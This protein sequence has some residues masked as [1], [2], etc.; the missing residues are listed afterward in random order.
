[1]VSHHRVRHVIH[2]M[3]CCLLVI[4]SGRAAAQEESRSVTL[5]QAVD[6]AQRDGYQA[7]AAAATRDAAYLRGDAFF[8]GLLPQLSLTGNL[9][10]YNRSIIEAPQPDG[11]TLFRPQNQTT[12][13]LTATLSQKVPF[14]GGDVFV[15]SSLSRLSLTG[16][17]DLVT[18]SS[19][20]F[21][22]G[23][24]QPILRPNTVGWD[25]KEQPVRT[26]LA[27]REYLEARE[28]I[29]VETTRLFFDA[30][31]AR[32]ELETATSNA[33]VN[34][35]LYTLN[36]GRFEIGTI[37]ENDLLQSELALLRSRTN[38]DQARLQYERA[39]A[40][41][42]IQLHLNSG[43][44]L[45]VVVSG[46]V[47]AFE[48]DSAVAAAEALRNLSVVRNVDLQHLQ[49]NRRVTE[50]KLNNGVGGTLQASYGFNATAPELSGVYN[51][52]LEAQRLTL[53][54]QVP[55]IR[56][57]AGKEEVRAA[58]ADRER[59]ESLAQATLEQT[60][61]E[62]RFAALELAQAKRNLTLSAA[63]DTVAGKR[64]EVAYNRYVIGRIAL[65][66][67]YIAQGEKDQ[68]RLQY[69]RALRG[70]WEAYYR[71]RRVTLYDFE[72][73]E[74]IR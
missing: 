21:T 50:A 44:P 32:V 23:L 49:A 15:S 1:M 42:R 38:L 31:A 67:L 6:L 30:Y 65:D 73:D 61:H 48:P 10:S 11:S 35:T 64:F 28:D 25:R 62:A 72:R 51:N 37:G 71:L 56:W 3:V 34:D 55:L 45:E 5:T 29:A 53:S 14:T 43:A 16:T 13:G 57:G 33:A 68:A 41:L 19:T 22:V 63:A 12:A 2:G 36:T 8:S 52:L 27:Y 26:D 7:A 18:W 74:V 24:R 59:T 60:E 54:V 17:Q 46:E 9:P 4:G 47:P 70:Y 39:L 58:E 20:A 40:A 69:V 66:N